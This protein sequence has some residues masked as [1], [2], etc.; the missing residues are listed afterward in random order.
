[1]AQFFYR[2]SCFIFNLRSSPCSCCPG[3]DQAAS[4]NFQFIDCG[5]YKY[6]LGRLIETK[7][8]CCIVLNGI[9][10]AVF[11]KK[12]EFSENEIFKKIK[13][14]VFERASTQNIF[15]QDLTVEMFTCCCPSKV[16]ASTGTD[17][18]HESLSIKTFIPKK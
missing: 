7:K 15:S 6:L 8:L 1:M 14:L 18:M 17:S 2:I 5:I 13:V 3:R 11:W 16:Q 10:K 9:K 12:V 4:D